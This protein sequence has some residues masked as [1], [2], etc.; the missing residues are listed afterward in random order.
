MQRAGTILVVDDDSALG[1]QLEEYLER[2]GYNVLKSPNYSQMWGVIDSFPVNLVLVDIGFYNAE[3]FDLVQRLRTSNVDQV[4][5]LEM[6]AD[7]YVIKPF[8]FRNLLARIRSVLRR[9]P[10]V[11]QRQSSTV[12]HLLSF[13]K[14]I[15]DP[16][17]NRLSSQSG[18]EQILSAK[19]TAL[20]QHL[21]EHAGQVLSR[22]DLMIA[23]TGRH[24]EY[25]DRSIDILISRL[26]KKIEI[27][28]SNPRLI[29][30]VHGTGYVF[31]YDRI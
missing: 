15:F 20:L 16:S 6:G 23:T 5:G 26:R 29:K 17:V 27:D 18:E 25:M 1:I 11:S 14:W 2:E 13:G 8:D 21:A 7:D 30:T 12:S 4:V 3:S 9:Y 28:T 22:Q 10:L 31:N 19:E 24:W